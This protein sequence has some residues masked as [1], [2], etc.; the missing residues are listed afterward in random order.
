[1]A[2][3]IACP[4]SCRK[5]FSVSSHP[6]TFFGTFVSFLT[7]CNNYQYI[8]TPLFPAPIQQCALWAVYPVGMY[9]APGNTRAFSGSQPPVRRFYNMWLCHYTDCALPAPI[10]STFVVHRVEEALK[11]T[12]C[13]LILSCVL[14]IKTVLAEGSTAVTEL[15]C[16]VVCMVKHWI[17]FPNDI[18]SDLHCCASKQPFVILMSVCQ[19]TVA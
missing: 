6:R 13:S 12:A 18:G 4:S 3:Y 1:M 9:R 10:I 15:N 14:E 2:V 17:P 5:D 7:F 19:W 11:G 16:A 8:A